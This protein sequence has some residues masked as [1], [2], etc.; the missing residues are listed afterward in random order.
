MLKNNNNKIKNLHLNT[1]WIEEKIYTLS[2]S[3]LDKRVLTFFIKQ[4]WNDIFTPLWEM[5]NDIHL[6]LLLKVHYVDKGDRLDADT[7]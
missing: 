1:N 3:G 7:E 4:F 2:Y 5:N 6:L